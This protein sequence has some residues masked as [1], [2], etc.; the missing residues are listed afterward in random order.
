[1]S[2]SCLNLLATK[3]PSNME[4]QLT[5]MKKW[6]SANKT[7]NKRQ[8]YVDDVTDRN[9]VNTIPGTCNIA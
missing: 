5:L 4:H 8:N 1:M 9:W 2:F 6:I 7:K 3:Y